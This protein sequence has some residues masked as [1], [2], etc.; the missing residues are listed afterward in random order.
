MIYAHENKCEWTKSTLKY[1][2]KNGHFDCFKYAYENHCE[3]HEKMC[4]YDIFEF[5]IKKI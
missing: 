2:A 3:L 4:Y 1:A 5:I